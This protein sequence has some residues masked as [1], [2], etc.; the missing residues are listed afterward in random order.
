MNNFCELCKDKAQFLCFCRKCYFCMSHIG[1]H[2]LEIGE[3]M[4]RPVSVDEDLMQLVSMSLEKLIESEKEILENAIKQEKVKKMAVARIE[5]EIQNVNKF[6]SS[7][8]LELQE[9]FNELKG[10]LD[11]IL[12]STIDS[13][14]DSCEEIKSQLQ[15]HKEN[16]ETEG[17]SLNKVIDSLLTCSTIK[18]MDEKDLITKTFSIQI[19]KFVDYIKDSIHLSLHLNNSNKTSSQDSP[20]FSTIKSPNT[21]EFSGDDENDLYARLRFSVNTLAEHPKLSSRYKTIMYKSPQTKYRRNAYT[22]SATSLKHKK[23]I[24]KELST[25][26]W[27]DKISECLL[28]YSIST[29]ETSSVFLPSQSQEFEGS[30][31]CF[32]KEGTIALT[33]GNCIQARR[34]TLIID[35]QTGVNSY[36]ALMQCGRF[37]HTM[38]CLGNFL[39]A[40]GGSNGNALKECEKYDTNKDTWQKV[41]NLNVAREYLAA[42]VH[43]G[44]IYVAGGE[45]ADSIEAYNTVS[46][47]FSLLRVRLPT[48][49]K[50]L[51]ASIDDQMI[52]FQGRKIISFDSAKMSYIDLCDL[53]EEN[54]YTPF[55]PIVYQKQLY[56]IKKATVYSLDISKGE[57]KILATLT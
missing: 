8:C 35:Y 16:L 19:P 41:G 30:V 14:K 25:L 33:G 40:I 1:Q 29:E 11:S 15:L 23:N 45:G 55:S 37:N 46:N 42:C 24:S 50:T 12:T 4:H 5:S 38:V 31:W 34:Q 22:K 43:R 17:L 28:T 44:R 13:L 47:K 20:E 7:C 9:K 36:G 21:E 10:L 51:M 54:W 57:L 53:N 48:F 52:I 3:F 39:Y 56:F 18:Q 26:V 2:L 49:S 6:F 27:V 32:I